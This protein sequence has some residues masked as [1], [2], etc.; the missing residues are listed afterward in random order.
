MTEKSRII[1]AL[2]N[3]DLTDAE[4][5]RFMEPLTGEVWG[6]KVNARY[7]RNPKIV[8]ELSVFGGVFVDMKIHD[9]KDTAYNHAVE[10]SAFSPTII[11]CHASGGVD[12]M[13]AVKRGAPNCDVI[14]VTVLTSLDDEDC[15]GIYHEVANQQVYNLA[16]L[17]LVDAVLDGIVCSP[18][19]V[20]RLRELFGHD[21]LAITPGIRL[22]GDDVTDQK[23]LNTPYNAILKGSSL[24]VVGSPIT[25]AKK[26]LDVVRRI[27][28]EVS[29]ALLDLEGAFNA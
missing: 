2:D 28:T 26:A 24:L 22:P 1:V 20:E 18:N 19:E 8:E 17:A 5:L 11:N 10:Q 23:R 13:K 29:Q 14:G 15:L 12:M 16:S 21:F 27:N 7:S 6:S 9:V 4:V 25:G 3:M